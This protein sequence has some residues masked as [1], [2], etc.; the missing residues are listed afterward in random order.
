LLGPD[1]HLRVTDF[2]EAL[3]KRIAHKRSLES[4]SKVSVSQL[5]RQAVAENRR[6]KEEN[7]RY[8]Q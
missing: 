6:A 3:L 8:A 5:L 1:L 2:L 7:T 4:Q